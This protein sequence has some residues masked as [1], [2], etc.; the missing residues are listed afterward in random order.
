[1]NKSNLLLLSLCLIS[2]V[3]FSQSTSSVHHPFPKIMDWEATV[4]KATL[5][6]KYIMVDLS[7]DWCGP[8][9]IMEKKNFTDP[10]ILG[11]MQPKMNSYI[12][13][14]EK[15]SVG[16]LLKLKYGVCA[17]PSFLFFTPQGEYL[18]T[19]CGAMPREYWIQYI[20]DSIDTV[21]I[22]RPGIPSGLKFQWPD[23]VQRE[24]KM[25]FR[26]SAP[27]KEELQEFFHSC[28]PRNFVDF[29]VC[30]FY[31]GDIPDSLRAEMM[32]DK[33]WLS[34]NYGRDMTIDLLSTSVNWKTYAE[35]QKEN[36]SNARSYMRQYAHH[37]PEFKWELFNAQL[38][39][40][41]TKMEIDSLIQ[42]GVENP[43]FV[44][45][46]VASVL[47]DFICKNGKTME[48][49]E[50]ALIWNRKELEQETSFELAKYHAMLSFKITDISESKKWI[51]IAKGQA[52]KEGI[53][54]KL[55]AEMKNLIE[56]IG[57]SKG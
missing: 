34:E 43:D 51:R 45:E 39:Y 40:Y 56:N 41:Q 17:F 18:E 29:N 10:E 8:C 3:G 26:N 7:T 36:W 31:P 32:K 15:D 12:L 11:L 42:L 14:A 30:R 5:D 25:N 24:L 1:M 19:W 2:A 46:Y 33:E 48:H 13:D 27:K 28:N 35:I 38:F 52:K 57:N 54:L 53:N 20:K 9:K 47:I 21:P 16:Q 23:F 44:T 49:F 4:Q 6:K 37:F 50:Q 55:D 22:S